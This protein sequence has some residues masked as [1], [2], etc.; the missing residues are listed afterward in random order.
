MRNSEMTTTLL[1]DCKHCTAKKAR[2]ILTGKLRLGFL[3]GQGIG[4]P[5]PIQRENA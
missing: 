5:R 4:L 3:A 1:C 2:H